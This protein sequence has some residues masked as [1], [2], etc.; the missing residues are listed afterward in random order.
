M[1]PFEYWTLEWFSA[2]A[3]V[4]APALWRRRGCCG[5]L[6]VAGVVARR[7]QHDAAVERERVHL[8]VEAG[9]VFVR[10]GDADARPGARFFAV[11]A[12]ELAD[13]VSVEVLARGAALGGGFA[14]LH[15]W[16]PCVVGRV[17]DAF[18]VGPGRRRCTS[19]K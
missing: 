10:E 5:G 12:V 11:G 4:G 13:G 1:G 16:S 9:A 15:V 6:V 17:A 18:R 8:D 2:S 19:R 7:E 3:L 14:D